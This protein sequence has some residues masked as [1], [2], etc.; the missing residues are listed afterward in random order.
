MSNMLSPGVCH[1]TRLILTSRPSLGF[2]EG[3]GDRVEL[4]HRCRQLLRA[5]G[6][7]KTVASGFIF[8]IACV[9]QRPQRSRLHCL[10]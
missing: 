10:Q 2:A 8:M 3:R 6:Q 5:Q 4:G 1:L 9:Q 7:W